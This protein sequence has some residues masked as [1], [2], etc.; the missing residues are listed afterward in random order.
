MHTMTEHTTKTPP[1]VE[2]SFLSLFE[3]NKTT[4]KCKLRA[5][6]NK[7]AKPQN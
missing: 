2:S 5:S 7:I 1:Q 4:Y 3:H 6:L